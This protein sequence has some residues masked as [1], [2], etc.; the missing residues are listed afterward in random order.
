MKVGIKEITSAINKVQALASED[1]TQPGIML[2]VSDSLLEVCYHDGHK[3]IIEK[4]KAETCESDHFGN[5]VVDY[6]ALVRAIANCQSSGKIT[7]EEIEFT[8]AENVVTIKADQFYIMYDEDGNETSRKKLSDKHMSLK[9]EEAGTTMK[10]GILTRMNYDDI[11]NADSTDEWDKEELIDVLSR[12]ATEKGKTIYMSTKTQYVFVAN[13]AHVCTV[14]VSLN[15]VTD[16]QKNELAGTLEQFSQEALDNLVKNA[17]NHIHF[18]VAINQS[19]A[20]AIINILSKTN[21]DKVFLYTKDSCLSVFIDNDE[22]TVGIWAEMA[23]ANKAHT[24][25]FSRYHEMSYD[26]YQFTFMTDFLTDAVKSALNA[27]KAEQ[28]AIVFTQDAEGNYV[29]NINSSN[30]G[31]SISDIYNVTALNLNTSLTDILTKSFNISL[32][33]LS[34]M[35]AQVKTD[36]VALDFNIGPDGTTCLRVGEIDETKLADEYTRAKQATPE[37]TPAIIAEYRART[38]GTRQYTLLKK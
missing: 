1:K 32:K 18:A 31:A 4:L 9:W 28:V 21:S 34:D 7:V 6:S 13:Q 37:L 20:K 16:E 15:E 27:S 30:A 29:M 3:S 23:Q 5:T 19:I 36:R 25:S 26:A 35:L 17:Q 24:G 8:W 22:E 12:C 10:S 11:F 33:V 2:R 14:P 38:L